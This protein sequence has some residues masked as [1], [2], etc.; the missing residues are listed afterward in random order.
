M[1]QTRSTDGSDETP[2]L[3]LPDGL[4]YVRTAEFDQDSVPAGLLRAHRVATNTW[5]HLVVTQGALAFTFEDDPA[6]PRRLESGDTQ[7]I[8]PDRMHHVIL[9]GDVSFGIEFY[10]SPSA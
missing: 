7:P 8:P 4:E 10:R 2:G 5:G 6:P 1:A 9:L 3:R